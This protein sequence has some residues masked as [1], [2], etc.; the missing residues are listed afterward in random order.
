MWV[1]YENTANVVS[2]TLMLCI[3]VVRAKKKGSEHVYALKIMDKDFIIKENKVSC[4]KLE[5]IVLDQLDHPGIVGLYF[6]FQDARCLCK[7]YHV[8]YFL[9]CSC[10]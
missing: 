9:K 1:V 3:Q 2:D 6:T 10:A 4:V 5:R 8:F 7:S